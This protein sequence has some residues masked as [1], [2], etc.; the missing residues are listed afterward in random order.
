MCDAERVRGLVQKHERLESAKN[1]ST[2]GVATPYF[3]ANS[4]AFAYA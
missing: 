1:K 4:F 2:G 3:K